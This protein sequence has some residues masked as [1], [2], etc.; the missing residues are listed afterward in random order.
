MKSPESGSNDVKSEVMG[1]FL[2]ISLWESPSEP[3]CTD[4]HQYRLFTWRLC[5]IETTIQLY[6]CGTLHPKRLSKHFV[7]Y[8]W[9]SIFCQSND[10]YCELRPWSFLK[11]R[12]RSYVKLKVITLTNLWKVQ[13]KVWRVFKPLRCKEFL[14]SLRHKVR[15][16]HWIPWSHDSIDL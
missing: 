12:S 3:L 9:V 15:S 6:S 8:S 13:Q 7:D 2:R 16:F 4:R 10:L 14:V 5:I 11:M 1:R